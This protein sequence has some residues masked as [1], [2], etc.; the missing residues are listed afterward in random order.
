MQ[1]TAALRE[2]LREQKKKRI[3][4]AVHKTTIDPKSNLPHPLQRIQL[5]MDEAKVRIDELQ[6]EQTQVEEI[7]KK[8]TAILPIKKR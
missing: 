4:E 2:K 1:L 6:D 8:L 5:A 3:L 7:I